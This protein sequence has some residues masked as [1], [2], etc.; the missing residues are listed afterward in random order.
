[1]EGLMGNNGRNGTNGTPCIDGRN[2]TNGTQG[3]TGR[4]GINGTNGPVGLRGRDGTN[5]TNGANGAIGPQGYNATCNCSVDFGETIA[6]YASMPPRF[7]VNL[8]IPDLYTDIWTLRGG[9]TETGATHGSYRLTCQ[10]IVNNSLDQF[11]FFMNTPEYAFCV[12]FNNGP[13]DGIPD[14]SNSLE[15][16][17]DANV[18]ASAACAAILLDAIGQGIDSL[19]T[20]TV[21]ND[22]VLEFTSLVA[23]GAELPVSTLPSPWTGVEVLQAPY[24]SN[25]DFFQFGYYAPFTGNYMLI[26][27]ILTDFSTTRM[28][29]TLKIDDN[30]GQ[31]IFYTAGQNYAAQTV[32]GGSTVW[33]LTRGQRVRN[34]VIIDSTGTHHIGVSTVTSVFIVY[35]LTHNHV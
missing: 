8:N 27:N 20:I 16:V 23:G 6:A 26:S 15:V 14:C 24:G 22:T 2:G 9:P 3:P 7:G 25:V 28:Y 5:G 11:Y 30:N 13:D 31:Y 10:E 33:P 1:M 17:V 29:L 34:Q 32:V 21:V 35:L 12:Y 18:N 19:F 4:D